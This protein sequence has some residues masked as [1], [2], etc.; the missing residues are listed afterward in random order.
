MASS[1][2][3]IFFEAEGCGRKR[4]VGKYMAVQILSP[5]TAEDVSIVV[6]FNSIILY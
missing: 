3:G 6:Y 2:I 1:I 4:K 5:L